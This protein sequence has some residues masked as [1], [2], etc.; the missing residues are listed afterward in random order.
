VVEALRAEPGRL[1][2]EGACLVLDGHLALFAKREVTALPLGPLR[3]RGLM[4]AG[5]ARSRRC[6]TRCKCA[7]TWSAPGVPR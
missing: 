7:G 3:C 5:A 6:L 1:R 4:L 2:L